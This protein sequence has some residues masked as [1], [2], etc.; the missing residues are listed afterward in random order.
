M[1]RSMMVDTEAQGREKNQTESPICCKECGQVAV[2]NRGREGLKVAG[3]HTFRNPAGYSFHVIVFREAEGC[4]FVGE[5]VSEASWF[6]PHSWRI[7]LC[8]KCH[9]HLGWGFEAS[10]EASFVGLIAT[11]L[12][13]LR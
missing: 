5:A 13:G 1:K 3:E 4:L 2:R 10:G 6:P 11:R 12:T 9:T 7:A 8:S